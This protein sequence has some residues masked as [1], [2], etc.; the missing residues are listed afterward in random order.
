MYLKSEVETVSGI[1]IIAC[2]LIFLL[3]GV[4]LG[5]LLAISIDERMKNE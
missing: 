5:V 3:I 4:A 2:C 1:E